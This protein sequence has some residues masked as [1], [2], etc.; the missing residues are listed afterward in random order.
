[1]N[2]ETIQA[3]RAAF[4]R[5]PETACQAMLGCSAEE[6]FVTALRGCNQHKHKPGCPDA[7]GEHKAAANEG[8][9]KNIELY[10]WLDTPVKELSQKLVGKTA[11][12]KI[13]GELSSENVSERLA[14]SIIDNADELYINKKG[15]LAI[16]TDRG[17]YYVF[18]DD[19][20]ASE[21]KKRY[22]RK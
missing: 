18:D 6:M 19:D 20:L 5:D 15:K 17:N 13:A 1:M 14:A 16:I 12:M 4:K 8:T 10:G 9:G 2:E 22:S 7:E 21:F 3:A 11:T